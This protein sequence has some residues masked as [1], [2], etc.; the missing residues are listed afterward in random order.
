MNYR[1]LIL[2]LLFLSLFSPV[3]S[4]SSEF[5]SS[6]SE[7][8]VPSDDTSN[9]GE[10]FDSVSDSESDSEFEPVTDPLSEEEDSVSSSLVLPLGFRTIQLGMTLDSVKEE[11]LDDPYFAFRGDPD[12][13]L[14]SYE[15]QKLI[16]CRGNS[17]IERA[18]F[19][20]FDNRLF[21]I[22]LKMDTRKIDHFSF[23]TQFTEKYGKPRDMDPYRS[24]W[25]D[26]VVT[27]SLERPLSVKYMDSLVFE[28]IRN[29]GRAEE[30]FRL[31]NQ[32][33]FLEQ[34]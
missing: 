28:R 5:P 20:F 27:L 6:S 3:I 25:D 23:Y 22:I 2:I 1:H 21:V 7:E 13:S 10:T 34:F 26:G 33:D 16:E 15:N 9:T 12:V 31:L 32:K 30:S 19:Q 4:Q 24:I 11:L 8:S 17:Y 29:S 18:Y 14:L